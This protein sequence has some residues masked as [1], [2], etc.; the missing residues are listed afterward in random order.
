MG[1]IITE[2]CLIQG[3]TFSGSKLLQFL[4]SIRAS[5]AATYSGLT[6]VAMAIGMGSGG[7]WSSKY[8]KKLPDTSKFNIKMTVIPILCMAGLGLLRC[9]Q[10]AIVGLT[11]DFQGVRTHLVFMRA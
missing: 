6:I 7:W 4:F 11:Q 5:E 8:H 3:F 2:G 1:A 10:P 9:E